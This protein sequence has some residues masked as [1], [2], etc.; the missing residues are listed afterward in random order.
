M[1]WIIVL[2]SML[3][4]ASCKRGSE[5]ISNLYYKAKMPGLLPCQ[6]IGKIPRYSSFTGKRVALTLSI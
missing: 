5:G 3:V 4:M 2:L 1:R 6:P